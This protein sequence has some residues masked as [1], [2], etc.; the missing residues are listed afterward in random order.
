MTVTVTVLQALSYDAVLAIL[1]TDMVKTHLAESGAECG[2]CMYTV[3]THC[4]FYLRNVIVHELK[5]MCYKNIC[6]S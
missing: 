4:L 3:R 2:T 1:G 5:D 6:F